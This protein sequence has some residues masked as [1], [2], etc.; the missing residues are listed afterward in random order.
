[1][2]FNVPSGQTKNLSFGP[3]ILYVTTNFGAT[4]TPNVDLGYC[5]GAGLQVTRDKLD[6][7]QGSPKT[8]VNTYAVAEN[9]T[10]QFTGLEWNLT[11]LQYLLGTSLAPSSNNLAVGGGGSFSNLGLLFRHIT[12]SGGTVEIHIWNGQ[13]QGELNIPF[14]DDLQE[15]S[16]SFRALVASSTQGAW[17]PAYNATSGN[18]F[19]VRYVASP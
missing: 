3:G 10:L 15:F 6:V 13:G 8:L 2:A 14:G 11:S 18:L 5:R 17:D 7:Q 1:M 12:P 16:Y 19:A 9:A 4:N